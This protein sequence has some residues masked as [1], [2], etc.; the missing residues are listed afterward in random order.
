V[1]VFRDYDDDDDDDCD[2]KG[3]IARAKF[4]PPKAGNLMD[5]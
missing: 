1:K 4:T 2:E 3:Q 5:F